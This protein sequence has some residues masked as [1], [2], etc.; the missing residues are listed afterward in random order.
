MY[1]GK[2][3]SRED[4]E[5]AKADENSNGKEIVGAAIVCRDVRFGEGFRG[6]I[7]VEVNVILELESVERFNN[8]HKKQLVNLVEMKMD[9]DNI[10]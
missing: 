10:T 2:A 6:D 9:K 5:I 4:A 7:I 8:A 1:Q 3:G